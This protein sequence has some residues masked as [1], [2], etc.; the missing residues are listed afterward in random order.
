MYTIIQI[1]RDILN[2]KKKNNQKNA[3]NFGVSKWITFLHA[4]DVF[5]WSWKTFGM[6]VGDVFVLYHCILI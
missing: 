2:G 1:N 3:L 5:N 4:N 6:G